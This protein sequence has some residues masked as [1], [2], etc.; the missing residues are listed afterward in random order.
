MIVFKNI[1]KK[2][3]FLTTQFNQSH[4]ITVIIS[5]ERCTL[6]F[7]CI[8]CIK[9]EEYCIHIPVTPLKTLLETARQLGAGKFVKYL[10]QSGMAQE[11]NTDGP[12]TLFAPSDEVF[13][14]SFNFI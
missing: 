14:V 3:L 11:L 2:E 8:K 6:K 9:E 4:Y 12:F 5:V 1:G 7:K 10:E 13:R